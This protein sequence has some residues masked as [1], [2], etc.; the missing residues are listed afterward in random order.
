MPPVVT[1]EIALH[2]N[3]LPDVRKQRHIMTISKLATS[4]VC[5]NYKVR[6]NGASEQPDLSLQLAQGAL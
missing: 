3:S 5:R 4:L 2:M 1:R 6:G